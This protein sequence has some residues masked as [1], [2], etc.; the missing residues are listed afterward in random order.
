MPGSGNLERKLAKG[1][2]VD[3]NSQV[4]LGNWPTPTTR[5]HKDGT[6]QS[7]QNVPVNGLLGR[8]VH[9]TPGKPLASWKT[10][11]GM[12]GVDATGKQGAGGEFDKQVRQTEG[13]L[14]KKSSAKLN[15]EW[16]RQLQGLPDGWLD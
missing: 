1:W 14:G 15:P 2:T 12:A 7:C 5:D 8:A 6:A 13:V 10:P 9:S 4:C 16:V 3:L 11:H